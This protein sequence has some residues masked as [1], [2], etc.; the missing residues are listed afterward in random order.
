MKL[1]KSSYQGDLYFDDRYYFTNPYRMDILDNK[2]KR[3]GEITGHIINTEALSY[4]IE[5]NNGENS[6]YEFDALSELLLNCHQFILNKIPL[7]KLKQLHNIIFLNRLSLD[8]EYQSMEY[9]KEALDLIFE[10]AEMVIYS[11]GYTELDDD[12]PDGDEDYYEIY[13]EFLHNSNWHCDEK[14]DFYIKEKNAIWTH[15]EIC[16]RINNPFKSI[17]ITQKNFTFWQWLL[18]IAKDIS[19]DNV[20]LN[21]CFDHEHY[22]S[23]LYHYEYSKSKLNNLEL[24]YENIIKGEIIEISPISLFVFLDYIDNMKEMRT[25]GSCVIV[26]FCDE[27]VEKNMNK[28]LDKY[29]KIIHEIYNESNFDYIYRPMIEKY[30]KEMNQN[31]IKDIHSSLIKDREN[32]RVKI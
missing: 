2:G 18:S 5:N 7:N 27:E 29:Y 13:E 8:K 4:D 26:S 24:W 21:E 20:F 23:M 14:F 22:L 25:E 11:F 19:Q 10:H 16:E 32:E 1:R 28:I 12:F 31:E 6:L 30:L 3:M 15:D 17:K 9:E